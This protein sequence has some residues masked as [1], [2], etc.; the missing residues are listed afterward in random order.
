[1]ASR[2]FLKLLP[3]LK[4][5]ILGLTTPIDVPFKGKQTLEVSGYYTQYSLRYL[6]A[7]LSNF[8]LNENLRLH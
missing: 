8:S 1:M 2:E 4:T 7:K 5:R 3:T 6:Y